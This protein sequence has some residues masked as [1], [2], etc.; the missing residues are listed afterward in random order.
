LAIGDIFSGPAARRF[1]FKKGNTTVYFPLA[2]GIV[3]SIMATLIINIL[4]KLFR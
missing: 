3:I 1:Y 4:M 2:T